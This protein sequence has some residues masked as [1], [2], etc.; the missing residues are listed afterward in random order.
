MATAG[1]L[2]GRLFFARNVA[3]KE[4]LLTTLYSRHKALNDYYDAVVGLADKF[5]EGYMGKY[6]RPDDIALTWAE[7]AEDIQ[8]FIQATAEWIE[9]N[10][11]SIAPNRDTYLQ[12]I[13]DEIIALHYDTAY[14]LTLN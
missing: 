6:G 14:L 11:L 13:L 4:H 5:A 12:N 8:S 9:A 1:E 3:H 7:D 10:R 2:I